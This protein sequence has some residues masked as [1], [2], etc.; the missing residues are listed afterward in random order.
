MHVDAFFE[1][2][3]GIPSPYWTEIPTPSELVDRDG[4]A[5]ADD[6]ALRALMPNIRPTRVRKRVDDNDHPQ[7][8]ASRPRTDLWDA[9]G[10]YDA[11][12][13]GPS[14]LPNSEQTTGYSSASTNRAHEDHGVWELRPVVQ[15]AASKPPQRRHGAKVVSSAWRNRGMGAAATGKTRGRPPLNKSSVGVSETAF[16]EAMGPSPAAVPDFPSSAPSISS[17]TTLPKGDA[18]TQHTG[19]LSEPRGLGPGLGPLRI[20]RASNLPVP[21]EDPMGSE[22]ALV[23]PPVFPP[24]TTPDYPYCTPK[25]P[26]ELFR[27]RGSSVATE[28]PDDVETAPGHIYDLD[29]AVQGATTAGPGFFDSFADRT[30]LDAVIAFQANTA[31]E[32]DWFDE[33]GN[34]IPPCD[35]DEAVVICTSMLEQLWD[36]APSQSGFLINLSALLGSTMLMTTTKLQMRRLAAA[37]GRCHYACSWEYRLGHV[38]G[39]YQMT[40][41]LEIGRL[42][43]KPGK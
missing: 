26:E 42:K 27:P 19:M 1:Y 36:A 34:Q 12:S 31:M 21:P 29:A 41:S 28:T 6:M 13:F 24:V 11:S 22:T 30:N 39:T 4:V 38:K 32:A 17:S 18:S 20:D 40:H 16:D 23:N 8:A 2:L 43:A 37:H 33:N 15:P 7:P 25:R 9:Q 3:L 14:G 10:H 5:P 35:L